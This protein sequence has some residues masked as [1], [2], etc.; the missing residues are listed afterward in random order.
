MP[1]Q[2]LCILKGYTGCSQQSHALAGVTEHDAWSGQPALL[3]DC[4]CI[5]I[6]CCLQPGSRILEEARRGTQ[7]RSRWRSTRP[8]LPSLKREPP[9]QA[10]ALSKDA[11]HPQN[12]KASSPLSVLMKAS[13]CVDESMCQLAC[14]SVSPECCNAILIQL[15]CLLP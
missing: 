5:N 1:V 7:H 13:L 6:A 3:P 2:V 10:C 9:L 8:A 15:F 12:I 11:I 4:H 14:M